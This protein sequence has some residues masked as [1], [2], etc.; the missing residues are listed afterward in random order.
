MRHFLTAAAFAMS[1]AAGHGTAYA[2]AHLRSAMPAV[3]GVVAAAPPE[4]AITF[5]QGVEPRFSAIEVQDAAGHR[6]DKND[7]HMAAGDNT[8]LLVGLQALAAGTYTVTWHA[9]AV[10]THKSEG[11]FKFTVKP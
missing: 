5:T 3:D 7:P 8:V 2:H 10:D 1:L 9:T 6:V 4:L 11:T